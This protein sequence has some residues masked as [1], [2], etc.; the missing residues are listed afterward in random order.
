M[1]FFEY[2]TFNF[3]CNIVGAIPNKKRIYGKKTDADINISS[4]NAQE[5]CLYG[6]Y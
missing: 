6:I 1:S 5:F 4:T 2:L 3:F